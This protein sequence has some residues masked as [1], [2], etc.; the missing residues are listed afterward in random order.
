MGDAG[1]NPRQDGEPAD[2]SAS[3][4]RPEKQ[5]RLGSGQRPRS[6]PSLPTSCACSSPCSTPTAPSCTTC[7]APDPSG[8]PSTARPPPKPIR[9]RACSTRKRERPHIAAVR[10]RGRGDP[11]FDSIR[12][13][14]D[15]R[16]IKLARSLPSEVVEIL[17][18]FVRNWVPASAGTSGDR[19]AFLTNCDP[20]RFP[21]ELL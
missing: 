16:V 8:T 17:L 9:L 4:L 6:R 19:A 1:R 18:I 2:G 14:L 3:W 12:S 5:F 7:A 20:G 11:A 15:Y 10:P 21:R 13:G